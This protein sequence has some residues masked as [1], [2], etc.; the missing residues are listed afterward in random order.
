[1]GISQLD[2]IKKLKDKFGEEVK[3]LKKYATPNGE[4]FRVTKV[5]DEEPRIS[6]EKQ[7]RYRSGIRIEMYLTRN[8]RPDISNFTRK[9]SKGNMTANECHYKQLLKL[10]K[11]TLDT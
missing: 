7:T 2:I 4:S 9:L 8:S 6:P 3:F 10:T 1:M 5:K 11:Y